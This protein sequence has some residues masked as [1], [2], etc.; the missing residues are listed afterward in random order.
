MIDGGVGAASKIIQAIDS[1][2]EINGV[3]YGHIKSYERTIWMD[4]E[5]GGFAGIYCGKFTH[6]QV[7]GALQYNKTFL[8][9]VT[10]NKLFM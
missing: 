2:Y 8:Q 9:T 4:V 3:M 5:N 7:R 6:S 1:L 10:I